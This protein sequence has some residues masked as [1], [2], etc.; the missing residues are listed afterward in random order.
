M[1][2]LR[3]FGMVMTLLFLA[4]CGAGGGGA[5]PAPVA[6]AGPDQNI[7]TGSLATL[8]GSG[9]S[10]ADGDTLTYH[11]SLASRPAGSSAALSDS[12]V[13][14]PA[15]TADVDGAYVVSLIVN[16]GAV[17]S[18][19]DSVTITAASTVG[20][21]SLPETGQTTCYDAAGVGGIDCSGTG[22]DGEIQAGV[23]WPATRFTD[24]SD[25]TVT[26][27]LTGLIWLQKGDCFG[28]KF[29]AEA[30]SDVNSLEDGTCGLTDNSSA[31]DWR[32]PNINELESLVNAEVANLAEWLNDSVQ[33]FTN[34]Q[35]NLY[36]SSTWRTGAQ[37]VLVVSMT[38]GGII[39]VFV[40]G[41]ATNTLPVWPVRGTTSGPAQLWKTGQTTCYDADGVEIDCSGTGQDGEIQAGVSWPAT[42]FTD[43]ID[44]TVTDELTGL[45][46]LKDG[47]CFDT[48]TWSQ[49]LSDANGLANENCDLSDGSEVGDWRL[50][51]R[52]ELRSLYNYADPL[53]S[54]A[55][56]ND[57]W[58]NNQ[59]FSNV[60]ADNYW[61]STTLSN[62]T[63]KA[64]RIT[65][66]DKELAESGKDSQ[67]RVWP[68]R[69]VK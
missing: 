54:G 53:P 43:H 12:T 55:T 69:A 26:D 29:W 17:D 15:F 63:D 66:A 62:S 35:A 24:N 14:N 57:Q 2:I 10:D 27:E 28:P 68:V 20:A 18:A 3:L 52:K 31:N 25:G 6:S 38:G 67:H 49:A 39:P 41:G 34:V 56:T 60:R 22:Q 36:W 59:G 1:K 30:L 46:W 40:G 44:G 65:L 50:P 13:V 45:I 9:S 58:L 19:A 32:L 47:D 64:W 8:D 51:N 61:T 4:S 48:S 42:R 5:N 23:S 7:P 11:W 16:D 21:V 33:K 37:D